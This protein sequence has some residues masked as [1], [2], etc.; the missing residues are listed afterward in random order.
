MLSSPRTRSLS[1]KSPNS[2]HSSDDPQ[3]IEL[4]IQNSTESQVIELKNFNGTTKGTTT[5]QI[6]DGLFSDDKET[7]S[8][9]E[10]LN[11]TVEQLEAKEELNHHLK[12]SRYREVVTDHP[13]NQK[14]EEK[15]RSNE[16][17]P[18]LITQGSGVQFNENG[19]VIIDI[20]SVEELQRIKDAID[21]KSKIKWLQHRL[22][23]MFTVMST[24]TCPGIAFNVVVWFAQAGVSMYSA[25]NTY[26]GFHDLCKNFYKDDNL[27]AERAV[28]ALSFIIAT[29]MFMLLQKGIGSGIHH[30]KLYKASIEKVWETVG[31]MAQI[32]FSFPK[33][34]NTFYKQSIISRQEKEIYEKLFRMNSIYKNSRE[35]DT[36][37]NEL[38]DLKEAEKELW[39]EPT[40]KK[41]SKLYGNFQ[42]VIRHSESSHQPASA[43]RTSWCSWISGC[44]LFK[45]SSSVNHAAVASLEPDNTQNKGGWCAWAS[46]C[47]RRS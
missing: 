47:Y 26:Y 34:F 42:S 19:D 27:T 3:N 15:I 25:Y 37:L 46:R 2:L 33:I 21:D 8:W 38:S 36:L 12:R 40:P 32:V 43:K 39:K 24:D 44:A 11:K 29:M 23:F 10:C 6:F 4:S 35:K 14:I 18:V 7:S 22:L 1:L 13:L 9:E 31:T 41:L 17:I 45:N 5:N 20:F 28:E 16:S 30:I